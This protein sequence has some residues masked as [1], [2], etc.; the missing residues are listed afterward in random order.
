MDNY[1]NIFQRVE[2]KYL[3]NR[4]Q[5]A[6]LNRALGAHMESEPR[7]E[8][9]IA[10]VYYDTDDWALVRRSLEKPVYK[11]KLRLRSYGRA[12]AQT[13]VF[14]EIKKKFDG[15]VYKRRVAM[16]LRDAERFLASGMM[17]APQEQ[18][19]REIADFRRRCAIFPK[20]FVAYDRVA[21]LDPADDAL[22][23]TFDR[24][25]RFRLD[26]LTLADPPDGE[27]L[28][29]AGETLMEVKIARA[30]PL[31][32][33]RALSQLEIFPASFSKYGRGYE[34]FVLNRRLARE[35]KG[36][37]RCA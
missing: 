15:V 21:L 27:L 30:M 12:D 25:I 4:E 19:H 11:E 29:P 13:V 31:W 8:H 22:R 10:N 26:R 6:A 35:A 33:S 5:F 3:V 28:L 7:G 24:N 17:K 16:P 32:L 1:Q 34:M 18:I 2:V 9:T 37:F 14:P 20:A 23:I 36:V